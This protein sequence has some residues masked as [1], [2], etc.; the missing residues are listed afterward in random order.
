MLGAS[1]GGGCG[2]GAPALSQ[3]NLSHKSDSQL[4]GCNDKF[5]M[6][7]F[8]PCPLSALLRLTPQ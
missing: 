2:G 3:L 1:A 8:Y 5:A 6:E 4:N 7:I